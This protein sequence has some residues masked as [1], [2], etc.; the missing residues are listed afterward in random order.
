MENKMSYASEQYKNAVKYKESLQ[1]DAETKYTVISNGK[2]YHHVLKDTKLNLWEGIRENALAYFKEKGIH[3]HKNTIEGNPETI[4]EGDLLSSQLSCVN[5]LLCLRNNKEYATAILKNIDNRIVSAE[6]VKDGYGDDGYVELE[7]SG[8]KNN[9]NPL[10]EKSRHRSRGEK[11]TSVDAIMVGKKDDEKN[12][13][14]FIEWKYTEDYTRN[15]DKKDKC[16]YIEGYHDYHLLF[17]EA[18]CPIRKYDAFQDLY[19]D[20]CGVALE[21]GIQSQPKK[22]V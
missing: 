15:Y 4:P 8:T 7:V 18:N 1:I 21:F 17:D 5:H 2:T 13:L 3:W 9:D 19:Y 14:V 11:S 16:K 10:K 20:P 12:M 22:A 6:I